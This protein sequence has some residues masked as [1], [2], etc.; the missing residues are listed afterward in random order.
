MGLFVYVI[1]FWNIHRVAASGSDRIRRVSRYRLDVEHLVCTSLLM[2]STSP[3]AP[4]I[5]NIE[6]QWGINCYGQLK[7]NTVMAYIPRNLKR[8]LL[9]SCCFQH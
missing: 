6:V 1:Y 3:R 2:N 9:M 8:Q 7:N 4:E 5:I